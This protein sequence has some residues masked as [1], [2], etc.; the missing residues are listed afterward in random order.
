MKIAKKQKMYIYFQKNRIY[1][2]IL[3]M[4]LCDIVYV[5]VNFSKTRIKLL[6]ILYFNN[7]MTI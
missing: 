3:Y 4:L 2:M 1:Y 7:L 5:H 6:V